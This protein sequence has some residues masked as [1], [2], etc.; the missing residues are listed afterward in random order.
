MRLLDTK[1]DKINVL[2]FFGTL[3]RKLKKININ[4]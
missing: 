3:E 4:I 2:L 1:I